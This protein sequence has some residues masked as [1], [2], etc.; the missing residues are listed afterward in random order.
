MNYHT[1]R[2]LVN[3]SLYILFALVVAAVLTV[4]VLT[5]VNA[6]RPVPPPRPPVENNTPPPSDPNTQDP[7][8]QNPPQ[9]PPADDNDAPTDA[10]PTSYF[11]LPA[12]GHVMRGFSLSIP[13]FSV[14]TN[15]FRLHPGIDISVP[16]GSPV[17]AIA[18]GLILDIVDDP[19]MGR[20]VSIDHGYGM[21][22]YSKGLSLIIPDGIE[23]GVPV[24]AGQIIGATGDTALLEIAESDRLH[25]EL[26]VDGEHVNPLDYLDFSQVGAMPE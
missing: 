8:P 23:V 12:H 26:R 9:D 21:V 3:A 7:P 5:F 20:T 25:F 16:Y 14:T 15:D 18:S 24:V 11:H 19:M 13:V 6:N 2:K 1:R 10:D 22:S 4:T 17:F